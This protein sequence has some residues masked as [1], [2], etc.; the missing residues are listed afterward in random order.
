MLLEKDRLLSKQQDVKI[1]VNI[2]DQLQTTQM[3]LVG[4]KILQCHQG[5]TKLTPLV[6]ICISRT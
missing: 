4:P 6:K 3:S 5:M 1:S 2:S